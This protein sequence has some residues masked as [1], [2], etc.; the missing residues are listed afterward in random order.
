MKRILTLVL[1]A[2]ML[3][4]GCVAVGSRPSDD[5][6]AT[7]GTTEVTTTAD[8]NE[9]DNYLDLECRVVYDYSK[10]TFATEG[11]EYYLNHWFPDDWSF[12]S[13]SNGFTVKRGGTVIGSFS[14]GTSTGSGWSAVCERRSTYMGLTT[15]E[16]IEKSGTG[17]TL[18]FRYR[19]CYSYLEGGLKRATTLTV[20]YKEV[21][22]DTAF[23]LY[24]HVH[25]K[26]YAEETG[27]GILSELA[28]DANIGIF[29]N[30]FIYSSG[31]GTILEEMLYYNDKNITVEDISIGM[32]NTGTYAQD[33]EWISRIERGE[34]D[35]VFICGMYNSE[36][37][38]HVGTLKAACEVSGTK[39]IL[40]PAH[41]ETRSVIDTTKQEYPD[42]TILDWKAEVDALIDAGVDYWD[43]CKNDYHKHSTEY[44]GYVGA[45]MIYRAIYGE[46]PEDGIIYLDPIELENVLGSYLKTGCT[47]LTIRYFS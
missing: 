12:W 33:P 37:P 3:F 38:A 28:T 14:K 2:C 30:S 44:A 15:E 35:A 11:S 46:L 34:Y 21:D 26:N 22:E 23:E 4:S 39:L 18:A 31:V 29:G 36:Q 1:A 10:R 40:F 5:A 47:E 43:M 24:E 6:A 25:L 7:T 20:D 13:T 32:A 45:Q 9:D 27:L 19:Y 8:T 42:L 41:N 16:Y 17:D